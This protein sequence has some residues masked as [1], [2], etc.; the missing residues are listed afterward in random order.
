MLGHVA[1]QWWRK[2]RPRAEEPACCSGSTWTPVADFGQAAGCD[3]DLGRCAVCGS[4]VLC[5]AYG[6]S[7]TYHR[8][9]EERAQY[10]LT[11][12]REDPELLRSILRRWADG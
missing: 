6:G 10:Y 12:L 4:Y 3:L 7:G 5:L 11:L 1:F 9:R 8:L 2:P